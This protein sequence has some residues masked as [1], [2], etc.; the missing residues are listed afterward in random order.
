MAGV[1]YNSMVEAVMNKRRRFKVKRVRAWHRA[2][3]NFAASSTPGTT[4]T[5][6]R[7]LRRRLVHA[8]TAMKQAR[9]ILD[10][11]VPDL[12]TP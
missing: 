10:V 12:R 9:S 7:R 3:A 4:M 5:T 6:W 11:P 8:Y 2:D 1:L